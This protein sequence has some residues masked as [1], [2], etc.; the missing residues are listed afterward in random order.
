MTRVSIWLATVLWAAS[1]SPAMAQQVL[2]C[3]DT[4]AVGFIWDK[5]DQARPAAFKEER[6]TVKVLS[7][8]DRIITRMVGDTAGQQEMYT[9][10]TSAA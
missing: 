10:R 6:Y 9:C 8:T 5:P 2:Y 4:Q 3:V 7:E 1:A